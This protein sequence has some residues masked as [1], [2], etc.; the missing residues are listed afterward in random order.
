MFEFDE[1]FEDID[2]AKIPHDFPVSKD[3]AVQHP[4][5]YLGS[6]VWTL[7]TG[8]EPQQEYEDGNEWVLIESA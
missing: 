8:I 5:R 6:Q 1:H 4:W 7:D 2:P 3:E